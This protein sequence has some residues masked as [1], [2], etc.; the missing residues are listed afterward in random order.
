MLEEKE[1]LE[2]PQILKTF[3]KI[4][5]GFGSLFV[6]RDAA[7]FETTRTMTSTSSDMS[8]IFDFNIKILSSQIYQRWIRGS[9]KP[10]IR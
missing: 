1:F 2:R 8:V 9:V 5:E 6:Y 3:R 10:T 7:S 4:D